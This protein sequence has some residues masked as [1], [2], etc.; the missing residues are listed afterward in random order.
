MTPPDEVGREREEQAFSEPRGREPH[1]AVASDE[2]LA[3][4]AAA[5]AA[6]A[7]GMVLSM[8]WPQT[9]AVLVALGPWQVARLLLGVRADRL[10]ELLDH[11]AP[12]MLPAVL[13]HL[14]VPQV[15]EM[16]P[17]VP[18]QSAVRVV[19]H[20]HPAVVAELLLVLPT[21]HRLALQEVLP[22]PVAAVPSAAYPGQAEQAVRRTAGTASWLDPRRTSLL[23]EVFGRPVQVVIWDR[24]GTTFATPE[25]HA[26][27][28]TTDWSRVTGLL[29]VTNATLDPG[30]PGGVR[31]ARQHGYMVEVVSWQDERDD[32]ALKRVLVRFAA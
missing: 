32:G 23:T 31:E 27:V 24:S 9:R 5:K 29:V 28:A 11:V 16:L 14:S 6:D 10:A 18:M 19:A 26:A 20:L 2:L 13:D 15:A 21:Q 17:L 22:P 25:L 1:R 30:L 12:G 4:I 3:R 8:P 7:A